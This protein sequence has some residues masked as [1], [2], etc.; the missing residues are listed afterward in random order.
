MVFGF[1][2]Y[3][4]FFWGGGYK[5]ENAQGDLMSALHSSTKL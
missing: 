5:P 2:L 4:H 3:K 1:G